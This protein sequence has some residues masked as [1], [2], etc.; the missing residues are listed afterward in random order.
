MEVNE[1][2]MG[3]YAPDV[4]DP[5]HANAGR[6]SCWE[7]ELLARHYHPKV[8]EG[9]KGTSTLFSSKALS[10]PGKPLVMP[11]SGWVPVDPPFVLYNQYNTVKGG[12]RPP[13][14]TPPLHPLQKLVLKERKKEE[15]KKEAGEAMGVPNRHFIRASL[16]PSP[17]FPYQWEEGG[18]EEEE[19]RAKEELAAYFEKNREIEEK[20]MEGMRDTLEK[21]QKILAMHEEYKKQKA[22]GG[23][24]GGV[25]KKGGVKRKMGEEVDGAKGVPT[26]RRKQGAKRG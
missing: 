7:L 13:P 12:F 23:K 2:G 24:K 9:V 16:E 26:K 5:E 20:K 18:E 25:V 19:E 3:T 4:E 8:R 10:Q 6:A 15:K 21:M 1:G 14:A 11:T 22:N 17:L